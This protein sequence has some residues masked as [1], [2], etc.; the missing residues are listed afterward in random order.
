MVSIAADFRP[1]SCC[2][3]AV[4]PFACASR[5]PLPYAL[6]AIAKI[7]LPGTSAFSAIS[8][9]ICVP[10]MP[11]DTR[12]LPKSPSPSRA[13][14]SFFCA[15][16]YQST[17]TSLSQSDTLLNL[18]FSRFCFCASCSGMPFNVACTFSPIVSSPVGRAKSDSSFM[19]EAA[20]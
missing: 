3:P 10:A 16:S 20:P 9:A 7:P 8:P 12:R 14:A 15:L 19:N 18:D 4:S 11:A 13:F 1:A 5:D 6:P 2:C 17:A